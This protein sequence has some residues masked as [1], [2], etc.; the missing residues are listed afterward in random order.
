[1]LVVVRSE[2]KVLSIS[3]QIKNTCLVDSSADSTGI[4]LFELNPNPDMVFFA[5]LRVKFLIDMLIVS[6]GGRFALIA[7][8]S[9]SFSVQ[10]SNHERCPAVFSD[11]KG[12]SEFCGAIADIVKLY[13]VGTDRKKWNCQASA[14]LGRHQYQIIRFPFPF[15]PIAIPDRI[16]DVE[17]I[18]AAI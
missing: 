14:E 18:N 4:I 3:C 17:Q 5:N 15:A 10:R 1:M 9:S 2:L 12:Q 6:V 11:W 7:F 13:F 16:D 8:Q